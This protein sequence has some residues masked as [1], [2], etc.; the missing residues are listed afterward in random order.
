MSFLN[1]IPT[2]MAL[3]AKAPQFLAIFDAVAV[4]IKSLLPASAQTATPLDVTWL[5]TR[6]KAKGFDPGAIDGKFGTAT[7]TATKAFQAANGLTADG[8]PGVATTAAL[9]KA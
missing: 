1:L 2:I 3:I 4:L 6:L 9:L 7:I 5:Q 8:W